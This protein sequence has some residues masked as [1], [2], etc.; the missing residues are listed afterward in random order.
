ML[1]ERARACQL[2]LKCNSTLAWAVGAAPNPY[3]GHRARAL[4][5]LDCG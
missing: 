3:R 1:A 2:T 5:H 4:W